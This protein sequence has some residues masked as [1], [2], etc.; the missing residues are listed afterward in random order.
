[1]CLA[2]VVCAACGTTANLSAL[3]S[4]NGGNDGLAVQTGGS[5]TSTTGPTPAGGT[6]STVASGAASTNGD[7]GNTAGGAPTTSGAPTSSNQPTASATAFDLADATGPGV[8]KTTISLGVDTF[9]S[10]ASSSLASEGLKGLPSLTGQQVYSAIIDYINAHGGVDGKQI[11]PVFYQECGTYSQQAIC[12]AFT[13]D[14]HVFAII[15]D[16]SHYDGTLLSCLTPTGTPL[17]NDYEGYYDQDM[18]TSSTSGF[19]LPDMIDGQRLIQDWAPALN[20]MGYFGSGAKVGLVEVEDPIYQKAAA[21]M[22]SSLASIGLTLDDSAEVSI[23]DTSAAASQMASVILNFKQEGIDHVLIMDD[24]AELTYLFA[25]AAEAQNYFPRLGLDTMNLP[26]FMA[27]NLPAKAMA[28]SMGVGWIPQIDANTPPASN[29]AADNECTSMYAAEG[30][31]LAGTN[32]GEVGLV[33]CSLVLF[34]KDAFEKST[35]ISAAGFRE[36]VEGLGTSFQSPFTFGTVFGPNRFDGASEYRGV[37]YSTSCSCFAY[38][39]G[40][41]PLP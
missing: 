22:Q 16:R 9:C 35:A 17:I 7:Q 4:S 14:N 24:G 12:A 20:Q 11:V 15:S 36:G 1:V 18:L 5:T 25:E 2:G 38:S 29:T 40:V 28:N 27:E 41:E 31:S 8:T 21:G 3:S 10:S 26:A 34:F 23:T 13:Q 39:T 6:T 19:Y 30:I 32:N 33:A 37:A